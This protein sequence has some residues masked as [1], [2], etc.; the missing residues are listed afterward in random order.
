MFLL[1]CKSC[2][3]FQNSKDFFAQDFVIK[4]ACRT[5]AHVDTVQTAAGQSRVVIVGLDELNAM[6]N[7]GLLIVT[8]HQTQMS[9]IDV[10]SLDFG[11]AK[12]RNA[13][14][15]TSNAAS[16]VSIGSRLF[17]AQ[18]MRQKTLINALSLRIVH[19]AQSIF[20][21]KQQSHRI[22][23]TPDFVKQLCRRN[24]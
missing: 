8:A 16:K 12:L 2:S 6:R 21:R 13:S 20:R 4:G 24:E 17:H 14:G 15:G 22:V 7:V 19:P 3:W 10:D 9:R 5:L 23:R 11:S 18:R 1:T